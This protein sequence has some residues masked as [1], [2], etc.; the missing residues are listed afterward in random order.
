MIE[1]AASGRILNMHD[2]LEKNGRSV[3][4]H[5]PKGVDFGTKMVLKT[6]DALRKRDI[7]VTIVGQDDSG[8]V[9]RSDSVVTVLPYGT[10]LFGYGELCSRVETAFRQEAERVAALSGEGKNTLTLPHRE[11]DPAFATV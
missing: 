9:A 8:N 2:S 7:R 6:V 3:T 10:K 5:L 11:S 4:M 1:P